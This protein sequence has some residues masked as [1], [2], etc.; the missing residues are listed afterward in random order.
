MNDTLFGC[1]CCSGA[2]DGFL[3]GARRAAAAHLSPMRPINRRSFL[4][5]TAA[6]TGLAASLPTLAGA[7]S[8][9]ATIFRGGTILTV[10]AAF[11]EAEA[12]AI[13]GNRIVAVGAIGE[14]RAEAG[15]DAVEVDLAGRTMLPG[16]IDP[17]THVVSGSAVDSIMT[18][19]GMSRFGTTAEV[20]DHLRS[21]VP[22]TTVGEW[23]LARNFD[24][25]LQQGPDALTFADLDAV[26]T[27]VPVFVLNASGHLAYANR[28]A[29]DAA[30][31]PEDVGNP[32]G[33]EFVR[34]GE[35]RLTGVMKNNVSFLKV[36]SAA[37]A[38]GRLD[39]VTAL[40]DLLSG[41][42][43]LGLTTVSEL[44]LGTLTSSPEDADII[45]AAAATGRLK[46]RIRAYPF[47]TVGSAA[48][49]AAGL[50]PGT[51]DALARISGYKLVADG[52]NQGFTGL[53]REPYLG[54]ESRGTAYMAP[55]EMTA[56]A[57]DRAAKGWPLALHA[58]GDAGIDMVLDACEEVRDAGIDMS[59]IR[60]RIEH[61]SM[62]HDDQIARM[63]DLG[64][65]ASFL[66]GHVHFWGVWMRDHVF[67]PAR[68]SHLGRCRSVEE[69]GVSVTLHSDFMVTDPDP[70]H[71]IQMAVTRRTWKEP[72]FVLNPAERV[73]VESGIR[74][75]TS[76]AAWQLFSDHEVG[77]LEVG[78]LADLVIL[79]SDPRLVDPDAIRTIRVS[80]TWMNGAQ[81]YAA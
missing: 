68:V 19:V 11:S 34:D 21:R 71:M 74:A 53:Q 70:L 60:A 28:K 10:D 76:E 31:V 81:V 66:I 6:L 2:F 32:P 25:A 47:Y 59:R 30:G 36:L 24:P 12:M 14:V 13:R 44:A 75:L 50:G 77:S 79:D 38:M 33:A 65:S 7:Q 63:K 62:L 61:C 39:P 72:D 3:K 48:W 26:S 69:A 73:S 40:I 16:F 56:V 4:S 45:F 58:N 49:D 9:P 17:H 23:I 18:N 5:G 37:P 46:A 54:S 1:P 57:V 55:E 64:V 20:L 80:E 42:S 35:G 15:Q 51:G 43:S 29:F 52:S 78:K 27:E 22:Q 67:G 41:W 8:A